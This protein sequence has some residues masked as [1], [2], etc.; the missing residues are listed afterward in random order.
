MPVPLMRGTGYQLFQSPLALRFKQRGNPSGRWTASWAGSVCSS[1]MSM[2]RDRRSKRPPRSGLQTI[3]RKNSQTLCRRRHSVEG[4]NEGGYS[5][6]KGTAGSDEN[7]WQ[8]TGWGYTSPMGQRQIHRL[9]LHS[10][11]HVYGLLHPPVVICIR[12]GCGTCRGPET[13]QIRNSPCSHEFVPIAVQTLGPSTARVASSC[14]NLVVV[15]PLCPAIQERLF[16]CFKDC[17]YASSAL[18]PSLIEAHTH[19]TPWTRNTLLVN[20]TESDIESLILNH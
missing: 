14:R 3:G 17:Q 20:T 18:T 15:G 7:R 16:S 8:E 10:H 1:P 19:R 13:Q 5:L 4:N 12:R 11:P 9:G 6:H 2:R